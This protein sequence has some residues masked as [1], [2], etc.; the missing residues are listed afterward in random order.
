MAAKE[1]IRTRW[2]SIILNWQSRWFHQELRYKTNSDWLVEQWRDMMGWKAR[3]HTG[4][5]REQ[6]MPQWA[7]ILKYVDEGPRGV[8]AV[9]IQDGG[10]D[11]IMLEAT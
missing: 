11:S 8:Q 5:D 2:L 9:K 10:N 7:G 3:G 6:C 4:L 1:K